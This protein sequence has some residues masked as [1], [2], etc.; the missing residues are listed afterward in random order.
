MFPD[1]SRNLN[2]LPQGKNEEKYGNWGNYETSMATSI[3][4]EKYGNCH[5]SRPS[6]SSL[7]QWEKVNNKKVQVSKTETKY[8]LDQI[9][10]FAGLLMRSQQIA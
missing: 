10:K 5:N 7:N 8:L 1:K 3:I 6:K 9:T 2:A 4:R